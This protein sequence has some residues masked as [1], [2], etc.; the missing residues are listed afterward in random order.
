[1]QNPILKKP[2]NAKMQCYLGKK[3]QKSFSKFTKSE[4]LT[5]I[6]RLWMAQIIPKDIS[7]FFQQK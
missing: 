3:I 1:M 6:K 4:D 5:K 7:V 2:I